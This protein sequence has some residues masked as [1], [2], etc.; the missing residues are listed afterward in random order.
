MD[1]IKQ[2]AGLVALVILA[3]SALAPSAARLGAA[4]PTGQAHYQMETF[5]QGLLIG[6]TGTPTT[7]ALWGTCNLST[8]VGSFT[9][10]T[11]AQFQ[12]SVPGVLA[13]DMVMA[14]LP[15]GAGTNSNGAGSP[16]GGFTIVGAY[17]TTSNAIGVTIANFTGA[18]TSSFAQATTSVEYRVLSNVNR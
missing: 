12:C 3:I 7:V 2:Y 17:A 6:R 13:G 9:A 18:A 14:D 8:S 11:T 5:W 4:N 1:F 16:F 10:S 15:V